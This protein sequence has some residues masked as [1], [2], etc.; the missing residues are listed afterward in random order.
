MRSKNFIG[1]SVDAITYK[2]MFKYIDHWVL[3]KSARSHHIACVNAFCCVMALKNPR[4]KNIYSRADIAGADG[5]P[6]VWWIKAFLGISCD[7]L[8]AP[9]ILLQLAERSRET[10]YTFYLYGGDPLIVKNMKNN[11]ELKF[12]YIR[13][14]GYY[15]PPFRPM[16]EAE[17]QVICSEIND[18]KPDILC[19]GLGTPKQDFWIEEH[20]TKIHGSVF[21]ACGATFDFFGGR[22]KRAPRFIQRSGF[23]WMYRLSKDFKRLWKR[24]TII[25]IVFMWNFGLQ[26]LKLR[27]FDS[28]RFRT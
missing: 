10:G 12:P 22:V 17:D 27:K 4:L 23:E 16:T 13:I 26:L 20:L 2:D 24:Y 19:V 7:R 5:V 1:V 28:E 8:C 11:L 21:I 3:N 6:F 15:S 18:L 14:V 9:D 25:N